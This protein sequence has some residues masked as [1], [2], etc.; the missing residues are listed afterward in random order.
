MMDDESGDD[1][2]DELACVTWGEWDCFVRGW[3]SESG[4]WFHRQDE[5]EL[6][7]S[8]LFSFF[9]EESIYGW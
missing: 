3:W 5:D 8:D 7:M 9:K 6:K 4:S 2:R 1:E